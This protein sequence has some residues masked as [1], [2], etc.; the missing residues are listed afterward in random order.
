VATVGA[1]GA[2]NLKRVDPE[3]LLPKLEKIL[4]TVRIAP[5]DFERF[6]ATN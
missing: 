3:K 6:T 2:G 4:E 5:P 1:D